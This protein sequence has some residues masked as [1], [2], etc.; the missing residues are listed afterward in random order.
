M[1][2]VIAAGVFALLVTLASFKKIEAGKSVYI[3]RLGKFLD[4]AKPGTIFLIPFV[5][6]ALHIEALKGLFGTALTDIS[7]ISGVALIYGAHVEVFSEQHI[8][9][10]DNVEVIE[11]IGNRVKVRKAK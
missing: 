5:D 2:W 10:G 7:G 1:E 11:V 4:E 3:L 9:D 6:T 8:K